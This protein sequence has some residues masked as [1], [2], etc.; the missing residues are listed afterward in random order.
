MK[1]AYNENKWVSHFTC[2]KTHMDF[3]YCHTR[4]NG[5][6]ETI[7]EFLNMAK[8]RYGKTV[9]YFRVDG[10]RTLG[11]D[12]DR[13][14]AS[15]GISV[16]MTAP[17]TPAQNGAAERA[18]GVL[19]TKARAMRIGANLPTD[20]WP[21]AFMAAGY[22]NNRTPKRNLQW[23]TPFE[24]LT[25]ERPQ[26]SHLHPFGCRAYPLN[27]HIPKTQKLDPRAFIGYLV[28]YDSTN[29]YRIWVPSKDKV[30]RTRD[31]LFDEEQFYDPELLDLGHI[32]E[33]EEIVEILKLP[34]S[35]TDIQTSLIDD[36]VDDTDTPD[37]QKDILPSEN[38]SLQ[39]VEEQQDTTGLPTPEMTPERTLPPENS[40]KAGK[41]RADRDVS[42]AQDSQN[43]LPEGTVRS[44]KRREAY[45]AALSTTEDLTPYHS[46]FSTGLSTKNPLRH[47]DS[48]P[49]EPKS[50]R[51]MLTHPFKADWIAAAGREIKELEKRGTYEYKSVED[52]KNKTPLPLL[53]VF[54]Y[55]FDTDG[56]LS[57]FKAR[58]CVRGD[59]QTTE[60]DT[61][62]ATLAAKTFRALMALASAFNLEIQQ[63]DA[64]NAFVNAKVDEEIYCYCPEGFR[65]PGSVWKL[66]KALYGLKQSPLLWYQE[67][68][69]ALEKLGLNPVPGVHC[70]FANDWLILFF[71][72]DDVVALCRSQHLGKLRTFEEALFKRFE[73]R[74][75][76]DM[77]WFLGIRVI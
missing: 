7:M 59:L 47:R 19:V 35:V 55:K 22:L 71:Y 34:E 29:I 5:A 2:C 33:I 65:R 49:M 56:Y 1:P 17:A 4:K 8:T 62:A 73:M 14:I 24:A 13:L 27:K 12:F 64:V 77:Q 61:Y 37:T 68:T 41:R 32:E 70:L 3:V 28:G 15:Y 43:I 54:K 9:K 20:L 74:A 11:R 30:V 26:L 10:E 44:R 16:E 72:V 45:T 6:L 75:L 23:K 53:W 67:M 50:W 36:L 76:G 21:E 60:Q 31:V 52:T 18:G 39:T 48:M 25:G 46:A 57:K 58:L 42:L 63:Y 38:S 66:K 51:Q 40:K 69:E